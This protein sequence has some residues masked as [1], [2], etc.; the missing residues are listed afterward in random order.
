MLVNNM[1]QSKYSE[2][3]KPSSVLITTG[4]PATVKSSSGVRNSATRQPVTAKL[5][6]GVIT[7][8]CPATANHSGGP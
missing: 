5:S 8:R 4:Y 1:G 2:T 6:S 7:T 3:A